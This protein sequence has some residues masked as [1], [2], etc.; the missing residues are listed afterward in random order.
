MSGHT[1]QAFD[2]ELRAITGLVDSLGQ[3]VEQQFS[4]ALQALEQGDSALAD[5]VRHGDGQLD[6]QAEQIENDAINLIAKRQP[7]AVDLRHVMAALRIAS[8]LER[9][10]DLASN[11]AKRAAAVI[12]S[13]PPPALAAGLAQMAALALQQLR[14]ARG[15]F[16]DQDDQRAR[17]VLAQDAAIDQL[18]TSLFRDIVQIMSEGGSGTLDLAHLLF[19]AK[20][21]E[22]VGDHATNIAENVVYMVS[23]SAALTDRPKQDDS[24]TLASLAPGAPSGSPPR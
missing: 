22:R 2:Q 10:G 24:S 19:I 12:P 14:D 11:I 21:I 13:R 20:N 9:A 15:A 23:G 4:A 6:R 18:H 16:A 8:N 1:V 3:Q 7:L 17:R 5:R